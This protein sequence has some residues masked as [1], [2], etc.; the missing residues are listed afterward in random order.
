[1]SELQKLKNLILSKVL[2]SN[3]TFSVD[4]LDLILDERDESVFDSEW[5]RNYEAINE[6]KGIT[7]HEIEE[8]DIIREIS[9]KAAYNATESADLAGYISDDFE[10]IAKALILNYNDEWLNALAKEYV[11]DM[12]PHGS[13]KPLQGELYKILFR[14]EN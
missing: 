11:E 12:I 7:D 5:I 9:F 3:N 13:L 10:L 6:K 4:D 14:N 2:L 8:I 1:M